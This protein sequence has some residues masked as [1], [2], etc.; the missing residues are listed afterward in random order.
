MPQTTDGINDFGS[1]TVD[2][3][4]YDFNNMT[5]GTPPVSLGSAPGLLGSHDIFDTYFAEISFTD[6]PGLATPYNSEPNPGGPTDSPVG[7][8]AYQS[9]TV[10]ISGLVEDRSVHLISTRSTQTVVKA[11]RSGKRHCS[12]MMHKATEVLRLRMT[13]APWL[14]L[15]SA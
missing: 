12:H 8:L 10:D 2:G 13:D 9:F 6:L 14:C 7:T 4:T 15:G 11:G 1:F 3:N 5:Y